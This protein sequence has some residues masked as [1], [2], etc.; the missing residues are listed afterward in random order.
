[1]SHQIVIVFKSYDSR[2]IFSTNQ[3]VD[4]NVKPVW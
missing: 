1:M 4:D 2:V 3:Q